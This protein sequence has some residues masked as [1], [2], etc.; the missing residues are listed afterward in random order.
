MLNPFADGFSLV[1]L[2]Q[3]ISLLPNMY[4]WLN[5]SNIFKWVPQTTPTVLIEMRN[6]ILTLVPTTPWGGVPPKNE[7]TKRNIRTFTVPHTSIEDT[8]L[9]A[10]IMGIR[11]FGTPDTVET[12]TGK[13][14]DKLQSMKNKMEQTME[15][16]KMG[17]LKGVVYDADGTSVLYNYFD[18]FGIT[19]KVVNFELSNPVTDVRKKCLDVLRYQEDNLFGETSVPHSV[20]VSPKRLSS[21]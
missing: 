2:S 3:S 13:V 15:W 21:W 12:I 16:R 1:D 11:A 7:G 18:E 5:Q 4:G 20:I 10:D 17:A 19:K 6:G 8:I 9:A 14:N